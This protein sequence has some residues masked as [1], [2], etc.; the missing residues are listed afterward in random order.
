MVADVADGGGGVTAVHLDRD[1]GLREHVAAMGEL[2]AHSGWRDATYALLRDHGVE[3]RWSPLPEGFEY[4]EPGMCFRHAAEGAMYEALHYVEGVAVTDGLPFV[5]EHAWME[6]DD[7][8][9]IDVTWVHDAEHD[10]STT[11]YL[12]VR[13][14]D[15]L[16]RETLIR[17][18]VYGVLNDLATVEALRELYADEAER[19]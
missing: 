1:G 16:L 15:E 13:V 9:V 2:M 11:R 3:R 6:D 4:L 18:E 19:G 8:R 12:G 14:P 5:F 17:R 7:G 10:R